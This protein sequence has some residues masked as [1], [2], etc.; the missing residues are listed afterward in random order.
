M[1]G[2]KKFK[3]EFRMCIPGMFISVANKVLLDLEAHSET[4]QC[5]KNV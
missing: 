3:A 2:P 1:R 5:M 4:I